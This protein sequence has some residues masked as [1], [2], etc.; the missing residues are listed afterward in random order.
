MRI[1]STADVSLGKKKF[2][3]A[4]FQNIIMIKK[5]HDYPETLKCQEKT[6]GAV[7]GRQVQ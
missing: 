3:L 2:L 5:E 4:S 1:C 7:K 6:E